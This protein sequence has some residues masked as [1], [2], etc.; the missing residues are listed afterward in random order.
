M[1]RARSLFVFAFGAAVAFPTVARANPVMWVFSNAAL[2]DGAVAT[3]SFAFDASTRTLVSYNATVSGGDVSRYP[4]LTFQSAPSDS[5]L[6][7]VV[8]GATSPNALIRTG[9]IAP[10]SGDPSLDSYELRVPVAAA[11]AAGG[12][13][14]FNLLDPAQVECVDCATLRPFDSGDLLAQSDVDSA[15][16]PIIPEPGTVWLCAAGAAAL[17]LLMRRRRALS[18]K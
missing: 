4:G 2:S 6:G 5:T 13:V 9:L 10:L 16:A 18:G 14:T 1:F 8:A 11:T 12:I 15:G 17:A 7:V 3:G